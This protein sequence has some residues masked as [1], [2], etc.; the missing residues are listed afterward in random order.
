MNSAP[1]G[2]RADGSSTLR[3]SPVRW[4]G[5]SIERERQWQRDCQRRRRCRCRWHR[6][7]VQH[8]AAA[9]HRSDDQRCTGGG[10]RRGPLGSVADPRLGGHLSTSAPQTVTVTNT[11]NAP[12]VV[13]GV[14]VTDPQF[15]VTNGCTTVAPTSTCNI[16][17]A[18]AP[19][20][21]GATTATLNI[22]SQCCGIAGECC[23]ERNRNSASGGHIAGI[24]GLRLG[25]ERN[26]RPRRPSR[27]ATPA[28]PRSPLRASA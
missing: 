13:T 14:T 18:F 9:V 6:H 20:S 16:N 3:C 4:S 10:A 8:R 27:S 24:A 21:I 2:V 5:Y 23:S 19:T 1:T 7:T 15:V 28:T 25:D 11:G 12:L 26:Q 17:V 22:A